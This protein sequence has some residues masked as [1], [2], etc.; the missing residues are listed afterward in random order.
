MDYCKGRITSSKENSILKCRATKCPTS[1][2]TG[3][4]QYCTPNY[5][6]PSLQCRCQN[7]DDARQQYITVLQQHCN[8]QT[9][10][11]GLIIHSALPF[12][13][14]SPDGFSTCD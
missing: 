12:K 13:G 14:A 7:E 11:S 1:I 8:L 6:V 3:I 2:V 10:S 5:Y 4:M 9:S